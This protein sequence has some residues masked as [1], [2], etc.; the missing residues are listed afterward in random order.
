MSNVSVINSLHHQDPEAPAITSQSSSS[1]PEGVDKPISK[2]RAA[3]AQ[4]NSA[5]AK[6]NKNHT[7]TPRVSTKVFVSLFNSSSEICPRDLCVPLSPDFYFFCFRIKKKR[8][9]PPAEL[10]EQEKSLTCSLLKSFI[11]FHSNFH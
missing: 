1:T 9:R 4:S 11:C 3:K 8:P 2:T 10:E 6:A 5:S 7:K